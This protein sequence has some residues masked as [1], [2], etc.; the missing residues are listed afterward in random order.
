MKKLTFLA[1]LAGVLTFGSTGL[2]AG[3]QKNCSS[4]S[5][6]CSGS[7]PKGDKKPEPAPSPAG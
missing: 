2:Y 4:T 3:D 7:C 6:K 1:L 5:E